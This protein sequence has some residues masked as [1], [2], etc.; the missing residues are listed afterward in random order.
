MSRSIAKHLTIALA[1][2]FAWVSFARADYLVLDANKGVLTI[3]SGT[4]NGGILPWSELVDISGNPLGVTANPLFVAPGAGQ[5]FPVSGS[6]SCSNCSG[7]GVSQTFGNPIGTLGAPG[8]FKDGSGNFQPNLGDITNG[9]WVAIK[10]SVSLGV[11]GTF[12]PY[13][14]GQQLAAAS[15]PVVLT[16]L[17]LTALT[18]PT[19]LTVTQGTGT[20]L[21]MVCD[22]GCS[23]SS[24]P[25]FGSAFPATGT[26]IGMS[27]GGNLTAFTGTA[28]A[29]NV[30][31]A[32]GSIANTSFGISG[33]LPAFA[34]TPTFN[35]GTLNGA[36]LASNQTSV[37]GTVAAGTAAANSILTGLVCDNSTLTPTAGQQ[38]ALQGDANCN[39]KVNVSNTN[40]N[41]GNNADGIAAAATSVSPVG[42]FGLTF[43]GATWDRV[44]SGGTTGGQIVNGGAANGAAVSGNPVLVG[45]SDGTDAR[46]ISTDTAGNVN[47]RNG[48]SNT[49]TIAASQTAQIMSA[50]SGGTTGTTGDYLGHCEIMPAT[51]SPGAITIS[52]NATTIYSF[53]GGASSVSNLVSWPVPFGA[54]SKSGGW[55]VTS[56]AN[57]S[58][59]CVGKFS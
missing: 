23:S 42:S 20:N 33:T 31:L 10:S 21:H 46:T 28:G 6:I 57:V 1:I 7:S 5:T 51:T 44:R 27:Q 55:K 16:A 2:V 8:G 50:T 18:P 56:G 54:V 24:S 25:S 30:N 58:L 45:G 41:I 43:N 29:L 47:T 32:S 11:T 53:A 52:D 9:Q 12:W 26:P 13:T 22:S 37:I 17:Q 14:I 15:V 39:L 59:F 19:T 3:K 38:A 35:L 48:A 40:T 34:A 49:N 36:A 4:L